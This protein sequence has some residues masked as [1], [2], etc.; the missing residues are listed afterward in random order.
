MTT[1][2]Q[3]K[4]ALSTYGLE[5]VTVSVLEDTPNASFSATI[6]ILVVPFC[7]AV[8]ASGVSLNERT[9]CRDLSGA[10]TELVGVETLARAAVLYLSSWSAYSELANPQR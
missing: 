1:P 3:V 8:A 6:T 2:H 10:I 9:F 4:Q 5:N 7:S